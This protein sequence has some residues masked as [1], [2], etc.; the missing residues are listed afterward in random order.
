MAEILIGTSGYA[1]IGWI[2]NVYPKDTKQEDFLGIYSGLFRT[3]ELNSSYY[4]MPDQKSLS[5]LLV[6]S[7]KNLTFAIKAHRFLT[8]DINPAMWQ[9][10]ANTYL[11]HG[12]DV[13]AWRGKNDNDRF[14]YLYTDKEIEALTIRIKRI[15]KQ[16]RRVLIYFNNHPSGYSVQNAQMLEKMMRKAGK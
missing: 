9:N 13:E 10:E 11:M 5:E 7:S 6:D 14:N 2:G 16:A 15:A 4:K 1:F 8:T 12:M 3:V